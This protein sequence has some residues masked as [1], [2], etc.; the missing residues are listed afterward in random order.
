MLAQNNTIQGSDSS[1]NV[2]TLN[3]GIRIKSYPSKGG[4]VS[5]VTYVD[6]CESGVGHVM[7]DGVHRSELEHRRLQLEPVAVFGDRSVPSCS[8]P[9][10]PA[11]QEGADLGHR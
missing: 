5:T 9:G 6:T 4:T 8:F 3:N 1:G 10:F 2:S 7:D 11:L